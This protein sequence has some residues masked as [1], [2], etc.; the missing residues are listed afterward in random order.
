MSLRCFNPTLVRLKRMALCL[1]L[2]VRRMFQSHF[3]SIKTLTPYSSGAATTAFQSHFGS[4]KTSAK[5]NEMLHFVQ[6]QSHFGSIK[7]SSRSRTSIAFECFNPTLVRLK[8]RAWCRGRNNKAK[9]Q[10][11]FGSIKTREAP[12]AESRCRLV[13]IPLWFD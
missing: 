9:F 6:F 3:G 13:S 5:K 11:H 12:R 10:S 7:T 1:A 4:I 8:R 2:W